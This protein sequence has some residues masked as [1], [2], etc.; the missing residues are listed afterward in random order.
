MYGASL[1]PQNEF[2][3]V[4]LV[5]L[6]IIFGHLRYS[7]VDYWWRQVQEWVDSD[8]QAFKALSYHVL[9][10]RYVHINDPKHTVAMLFNLKWNAT[11]VIIVT[12]L[13][14]FYF[15]DQGISY[16]KLVV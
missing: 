2:Y 12:T 7:N 6:T 1:S 4:F 13:K 3:G 16:N 9:E 10:G 14:H 8:R 5:A 15:S 11:V